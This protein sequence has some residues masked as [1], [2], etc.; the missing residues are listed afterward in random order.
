METFA[1][2]LTPTHLGYKDNLDKGR[3][4][5]IAYYAPLLDKKK[6]ELAEK[7]SHWQ[8]KKILFYQENT[9]SHI[10]VVAMVKILELL[11]DLLD[12]PPHSPD[13]APTASFLFPHLKIVL[14]SMRISSSEDGITFVNNYFAEKKRRLLFG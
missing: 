6:A 4:I 12:H 2:S 14:G 11:F 9:P 3:T 13:L 5:I 10:S 7:R 1:S 8:K